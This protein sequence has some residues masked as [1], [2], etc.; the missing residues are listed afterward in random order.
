MPQRDLLPPP[1]ETILIYAAYGWASANG[2]RNAA[3]RPR[4]PER[5]MWVPLFYNLAATGEGL[6][7]IEAHAEAGAAMWKLPPSIAAIIPDA[8]A[9]RV[10]RLM[11]R[12]ELRRLADTAAVKVILAEGETQPEAAAA[13]SPGSRPVSATPSRSLRGKPINKWKPATPS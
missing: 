6:R 7:Q 5:D 2:F 8:F 9:G 3:G 12:T 11:F 10:A 4:L 13:P 1:Y